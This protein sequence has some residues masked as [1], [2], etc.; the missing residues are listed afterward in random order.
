M[1]DF[2]SFFL[3]PERLRRPPACS[4]RSRR[5]GA[6]GSPAKKRKKEGEKRSCVCV[7]FFLFILFFPESLRRLPGCSAVDTPHHRGCFFFP[8]QTGAQGGSFGEPYPTSGA[9]SR[10]QGAPVLVL[11]GRFN[12]VLCAVR[13][14]PVESQTVGAPPDCWS[15]SS[16]TRSS[17]CSSMF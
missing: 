8:A 16:E 11:E 7:T 4:Q 5:V 9:Y 12:S 13:G 2:L 3:F 10:V 1:R 6:A 15:S 14:T 17:R